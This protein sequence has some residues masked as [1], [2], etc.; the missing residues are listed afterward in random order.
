MFLTTVMVCSALLGSAAG[1]DFSG[2]YATG[3][4]QSLSLTQSGDGTLTGSLVLGGGKKLSLSGTAESGEASGTCTGAGSSYYFE[5][6]LDG[7][8]L[9]FMLVPSDEEGMPDFQNAVQLTFTRTKSAGAAEPAPGKPGSAQAARNDRAPKE[10]DADLT[11][12][13][14]GFSFTAPKGWRARVQPQG[15]LLGHDSIAGMILVLPHSA[16]N[17]GAMRAE[18]QA[19]L[20]EEDGQL[21]L[22]GEL[23]QSGENTLS[24]DYTGSWQGEKT[25]ARGIGTL[26]PYGGGAYVIAAAAPEKFSSR[27][28]QAGLD[29]ARSIRYKR[30][31]GTGLTE[32]FAGTW[33]NY[34]KSTATYVHLLADGTYA[35][36][37]E[38]SYSGSSSDQYGNE[39]L[40]WGTARSDQTSGRWTARGTKEQGVLVITYENGN[41]REIEYRVHVE[42]GQTYWSEYYFNGEL[43]GKK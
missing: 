35:E 23:K 32:H 11:S 8:D 17:L 5:A 40:T 9:E 29:L 25:K 42:N 43:Y 14:W 34:T 10:S 18:M 24:G 13:G 21:V 36:N 28:S 33:Y 6:E 2:T 3:E 27:L 16:Q 4:G 20:E 15:A 22:S 26:S 41:Q 39:D 38:A 37:Y 30:V 12:A 31:A 7:N 1:Q 19:G